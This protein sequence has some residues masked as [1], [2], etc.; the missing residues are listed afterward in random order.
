[1]VHGYSIVAME[2]FKYAGIEPGFPLVRR[3]QQSSSRQF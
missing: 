3:R 1:M 2:G